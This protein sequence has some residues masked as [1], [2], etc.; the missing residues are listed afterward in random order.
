[1]GFF[2]RLKTGWGLAMDSLDVLRD[3]PELAVFPFVAGVAGLLYVGV[4]FGVVTVANV[5][6]PAGYVAL[7]AFYVGT[8]FVASFFTAGLVHETREAFAGREPSFRGGLAAAWS[9]VGTLL[10][11]ALVAATVG[12]VIRAV[13]NRSGVVGDVVAGLIGVAWS[14]LTYF[15]VPVIVFEDVGVT[16][17]ISRSG[18][19]FKDTWGETA[20]AGFG[21]GLVTLLFVGAA[22]AVGAV[23]VVA[24]S[25]VGSGLGT[26]G[27]LAVGAVLVVIAY[28]ASVTLGAIARTALYVYAAE[29][30][31]PAQFGDVDFSRLG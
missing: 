5:R 21:V 22:L 30:E 7:F 18:Q 9:N 8:T 17:A 12:L 10:A 20:G 11:W 15:V 2:T 19:T 4:L 26:V 3:D 31:T 24:A 28:L 23:L 16:D 25:S 13:E 29:G 6:G 14:I 1:M 27:A